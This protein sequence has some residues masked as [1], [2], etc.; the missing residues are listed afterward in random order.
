MKLITNIG[1]LI[2]PEVSRTQEDVGRQRDRAVKWQDHL[3]QAAEDMWHNFVSTQTIGRRA[4]RVDE[5]DF[6]QGES[7][8]RLQAGE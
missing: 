1:G 6:G 3:V 2:Y 4:G 8:A 5:V 7:A